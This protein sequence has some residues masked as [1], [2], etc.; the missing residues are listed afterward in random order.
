MKNTFS[1]I[2]NLFGGMSN[3]QISD[4][5]YNHSIKG[6]FQTARNYHGKKIAALTS[7]DDLTVEQLEKI[8]NNTNTCPCCGKKFNSLDDAQVCH[9]QADGNFTKSNIMFLCEECNRMQRSIFVDFNIFTRVTNQ[10]FLDFFETH[11]SQ[12]IKLLNLSNKD[13]VRIINRMEIRDNEGR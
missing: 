7:A 5:K 1:T 3:N 2:S 13:V 10:C 8:W 9:I 12:V 6:R 4:I 11:Q